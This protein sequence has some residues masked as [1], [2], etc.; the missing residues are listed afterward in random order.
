MELKHGEIAAKP[1][2]QKI[3]RIGIIG[4]TVMAAG[5]IYFGTQ[6]TGSTERATVKPAAAA[7]IRIA[8]AEGTGGCDA[9]FNDQIR[10]DLER[11]V[12]R[13]VSPRSGQIKSEL[14]VAEGSYLT[15][16]IGVDRAG[17]PMIEDV[18]ASSGGREE[19]D[20]REVVRAI[21]LSFDGVVLAAPAQGQRCSYT[22]SSKI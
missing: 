4:A 19:V 10:Q 16:S 13:A 3:A 7:E 15:F 17:R 12:E 1:I 8:R 9:V 18:W 11:R 14:G 21:G 22:L 20:A 2:R 6:R 5:I